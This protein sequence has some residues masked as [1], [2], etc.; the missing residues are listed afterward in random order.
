MS[1]TTCVQTGAFNTAGLQALQHDSNRD[2]H[3]STLELNLSTFGTYPLVKL[4]Y[5]GD[6][7]S[8]SGAEMGSSG[9][10]RLQVSK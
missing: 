9:S 6:K 3:S 7:D 10:P 8:S 5:A 2:L 4:R 1:L